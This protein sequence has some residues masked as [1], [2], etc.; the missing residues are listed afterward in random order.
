MMGRPVGRG[1]LMA[2]LLVGA[3]K[4]LGMAFVLEGLVSLLVYEFGGGQSN[5]GI[6][7]YSLPNW[8]ADLKFTLMFWPIA[9]PICLAILCLALGGFW[10]VFFGG[11]GLIWALRA[12]SVPLGCCVAWC[13]TNEL[14]TG[15]PF[16]YRGAFV[17][18]AFV[19]SPWII[20][21]RRRKAYQT[22]DSTAPNA[23]GASS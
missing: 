11:R 13:L 19:L 12:I 7:G 5:W 8:Q 22:T 10:S 18:S 1:G 2:T 21:I 9:A 6:D 4:L 16:D 14:Q 15:N 17:I 20:P 23:G 3:R